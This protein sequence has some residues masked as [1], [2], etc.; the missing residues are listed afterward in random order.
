MKIVN[1]LELKEHR[2]NKITLINEKDCRFKGR[3]SG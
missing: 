2:V 1:F 3:S